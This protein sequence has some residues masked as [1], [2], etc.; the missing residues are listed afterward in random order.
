MHRTQIS[1]EPDQYRKL[2]QEAQ[3]LGISASA[4]IWQLIDDYLRCPA[5]EPEDPLAAITGIGRGGAEPTGREH[6]RY[7]YSSLAIA[8]SHSAS[9]E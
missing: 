8:T 9:P 4:L 3:R 1:L 7:L 2:G 5:P 6:N